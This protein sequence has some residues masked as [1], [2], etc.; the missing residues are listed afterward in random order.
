MEEI[1]RYEANP[2]LARFFEKPTN[3]FK[4][5]FTECNSNLAIL[6]TL[7]NEKQSNFLETYDYML[8]PKIKRQL[9]LVENY[10]RFVNF[11]A[12]QTLYKMP[13]LL[14][15]ADGTKALNLTSLN[16]K[17]LSLKWEFP[18]IYREGAS[19]TFKQARSQIEIKSF[20]RNDLLPEMKALERSSNLLAGTC[21]ERYTR[22]D[23]IW[24][25]VFKQ[26]EIR[27]RPQN[28]SKEEPG[29]DE[30]YTLKGWHSG[31]AFDYFGGTHRL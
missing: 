1:T 16:E 15:G 5:E 13:L 29:T 30:F 20:I 7:L 22:E 14:N 25:D 8:A 12:R 23:L 28:L 6:E 2:E 10:A 9:L 11:Y 4:N 21:K 3:A 17:E 26:D 19:M 27:F 31:N 18:F 24:V